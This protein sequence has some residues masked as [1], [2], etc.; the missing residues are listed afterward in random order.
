[1]ARVAGA[2]DYVGYTGQ[3]SIRYAYCLSSGMS[4]IEA[5]AT[6]ESSPWAARCLEGATPLL[7]VNDVQVGR[8]PIAMMAWMPPI[9]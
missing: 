9:T 4:L 1:M 8:A 3:C 7:H 2:M 5:R 6:E